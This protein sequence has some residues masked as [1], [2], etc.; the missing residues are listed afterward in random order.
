M[1]RPFTTKSTKP[2]R[3]KHTFVDTV[4]AVEKNQFCAVMENNHDSKNK[5]SV[6]KQIETGVKVSD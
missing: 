4:I 1:M 3:K 6:P 2:H 5:S